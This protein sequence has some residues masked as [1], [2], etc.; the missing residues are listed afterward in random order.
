MLL[1]GPELI[2]EMLWPSI[3]AQLLPELSALIGYCSVSKA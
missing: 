1:N 2:K 3:F